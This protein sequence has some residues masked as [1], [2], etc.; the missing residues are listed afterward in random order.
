MAR[1]KPIGPKRRF[2]QIKKKPGLFNKSLAYGEKK[3]NKFVI[4]S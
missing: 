3:D 4:I 2:P 1:L